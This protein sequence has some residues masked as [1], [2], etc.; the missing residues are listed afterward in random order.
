MM[1]KNIITVILWHMPY[2]SY[3]IIANQTARLNPVVKKL[4]Q[5]YFDVIRG[6]N[7]KYLEWCTPA[8]KK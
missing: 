1:H 8:Y 7:S 6:N 2:L 3:L 4:Q 5:L